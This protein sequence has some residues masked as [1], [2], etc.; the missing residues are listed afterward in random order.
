MNPH[1]ATSPWRLSEGLLVLLY[2]PFVLLN[3]WNVPSADDFVLADRYA[4][5]GFWGMQWLFYQ[6]WTGRYAGIFL[7]A[8]F[9]AFWGKLW[10]YRAFSLTLVMAMPLAFNAFYKGVLGRTENDTRRVMALLSSVLLLCGM[11]SLVQSVYWMAGS[12]TYMVGI[13]LML[14]IM[15]RMAEHTRNHAVLTL[16][17]ALPMGALVLL[18][19]GLSE[20][21]M[22]ALA[23]IIGAAALWSLLGRK[24]YA[25]GFVLWAAL[26]AI[27]GVVMIT[28]PGNMVRGE[29]LLP[30][31]SIADA[32]MDA[33]RSV[34][35]A[36]QLLTQ[37]SAHP[38]VWVAGIMA[39]LAGVGYRGRSK[40]VSFPFLPIAALLLAAAAGFSLAPAVYTTGDLPPP[41]ALSVAYMLFSLVLLVLCFSVG[42]AV[43]GCWLKGRFTAIY[44]FQAAALLCLLPLLQLP[45]D[46]L[47]IATDDVL[48]GRAGRYAQQYRERMAL[49]SQCSADTCRIPMY[50]AR[51]QSLF[52]EDLDMPGQEWFR[53]SFERLYGTRYLELSWREPERL[54][55][56][57]ESI[58]PP[59]RHEGITRDDA[60]SGEHSHM[61]SNE[62]PY[63]IMVT[64]PL[65]RCDERAL[66][67][68]STALARVRMRCATPQG[69]AMLVLTVQPPGSTESLSWLHSDLHCD[70][71]AVEQWQLVE[72]RTLLNDRLLHP[73]HRVVIHAWHIEGGPVYADDLE[74]VIY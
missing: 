1:G 23:I 13:L 57:T 12:I 34:L 15:G 27:G 2:L 6:Q 70:S 17:K 42:R 10:V 66:F 54:C 30:D 40:L 24:P 46:N 31:K 49:A 41:R 8:L 51:P 53:M 14:C 3:F 63:G 55:R 26:T 71:T 18:A 73:D 59:A 52:N 29:G 69:M 62:V 61:V 16:R 50:T 67:T 74:L 32:P 11:P 44:P 22:V 19:A 64:L 45:A 21:N 4:T 37:W 36:I 56:A 43:L 48:S 20:T 35:L 33:W 28:A 5:H 7:M 68:F 39:A 72:L 47:Y 65:E 38:T 25:Q 58:E 60:Y 9:S